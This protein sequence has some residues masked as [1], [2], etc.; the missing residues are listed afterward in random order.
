[1]YIIRQSVYWYGSYPIPAEHHLT[2]TVRGSAAKTALD[3]KDNA[4]SGQPPVVPPRTRVAIVNLINDS[5]SEL[6]CFGISQRNTGYISRCT[7]R[8]R[9]VMEAENSCN[10]KIQV[11]TSIY[12]TFEATFVRRLSD[13]ATSGSIS[14][15]RAKGGQNHYVNVLDEIVTYRWAQHQLILFLRSLS[16]LRLTQHYFHLKAKQFELLFKSSWPS[17]SLDYVRKNGGWQRHK[18]HERFAKVCEDASIEKQCTLHMWKA[19]QAFHWCHNGTSYFPSRGKT[20]IRPQCFKNWIFSRNKRTN[21]IKRLFCHI[22]AMLLLSEVEL[23][24]WGPGGNLPILSSLIQDNHWSALVSHNSLLSIFQPNKSKNASY[25]LINLRNIQYFP[26]QISRNLTIN[27]NY[28]F[29][30]LKKGRCI[31]CWYIFL[32]L[33]WLGTTTNFILKQWIESTKL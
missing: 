28:F 13:K 30:D 16:L 7:L 31:G 10:T 8:L 11:S 14:S 18:M 26:W 12:S 23:C 24:W 27:S 22:L 19:M 1:M 6:S 33:Q 5:M 32:R 21:W 17:V 9:E 20:F 29:D 3:W 4:C 25:F 15:C 2:E